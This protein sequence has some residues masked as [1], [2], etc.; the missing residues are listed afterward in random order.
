[1]DDLTILR[2][3]IDKIDNTLLEL[4]EARMETVIKVADYK[5]KNELEIL[6]ESREK[7][8]LQKVKL[9]KNSVLQ[10]YGTDFFKGLMDISKNVQAEYIKNREQ[11][12]IEQSSE[13]LNAFSQRPEY[14]NTNNL[15]TAGEQNALNRIAES[16]QT[17]TVGFQGLPGSFSEQA[18]RE[19]FG[20]NPC[21]INYD[22]FKN[23]FK[24]LHAGE[25][26]YGVLPL[27]NS[28]TGGIAEVYDLLCRY[29]FFIIGEKC[30]KVDHNLLAPPGVRIEDIK[31][32]YSHP[33]AFLQCSKYLENHSEWKQIA[34]SNTAVS[35]KLIADSALCNSAA[36]ASR[37]AAENF[38]LNIL[39]QE[40][41]TS[42]NNY[43]RFIII[44]R[45]AEVTEESNKISLAVTITH[46]P[47][48]LYKILTHFAQNGLNMLKIESRPIM[49]KTWE[50]L[51][52]I[53]FEGNID[54]PEV[55]AA[56]AGIQQN[57][58]FFRLLGNYRSDQ[59]KGAE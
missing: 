36:I 40:I 23:I 52:Y 39:K 56:I 8:V 49:D 3:Q 16:N 28:L 38:G 24:A 45:D 42:A 54:S 5:L 4:F 41:N 53:D 19:Y 50:Y 43:T 29:G 32:V 22:S 46:S 55:Q 26:D 30:V 6:D 11:L 59:N 44:G 7:N 20:T 58:N 13:Q 18:L 34:C 14:N 25:I 47:G 35:A 9:L 17:I 27:E 37:R 33:Q 10:K 57:S 31:E 1:M 21:G 12:D 15:C 51:F 2:Q 48:S